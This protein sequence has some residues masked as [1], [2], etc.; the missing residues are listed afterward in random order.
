MRT[1][2]QKQLFSVT[3]EEAVEKQWVDGPYSV[4]DMSNLMGKNWLPVRRFGILQNGKL[5]PIDNFKESMINLTFSCVG[6]V[7]LRAMEHILWMT[8]TIIKYLLHFGE[9]KFVLSDGTELKGCVHPSWRAVPLG[10]EATCV[11]MKLAYKQPQGDKCECTII[12]L[13]CSM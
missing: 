12:C 2:L 11:D 1:K 9:V 4:E 10:V 13:M 8:V 5:R 3:L 6:R 7:E